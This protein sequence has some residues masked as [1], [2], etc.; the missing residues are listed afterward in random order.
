MISL[1]STTLSG[2][3]MFLVPTP[4]AL[5]PAITFHAFGVKTSIAGGSNNQPARC[6]LNPICSRV[7]LTSLDTRATD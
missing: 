6:G 4:G 5:P 1:Q 7:V 2:S 3:E